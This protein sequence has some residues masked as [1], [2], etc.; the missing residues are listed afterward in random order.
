MTRLAQSRLRAGLCA[1]A[2]AGALVAGFFLTPAATAQPTTTP[3]AS[4]TASPSVT[5]S[6]SPSESPARAGGANGPSVGPVSATDAP[7]TAALPAAV[8]AELRKR[9]AEATAE[10]TTAQTA[11]DAANAQALD[12]AHAAMTA[13]QNA[14]RARDRLTQWAGYL[15]RVSGNAGLISQIFNDP[16]DDPL[17]FIRGA[18]D[19]EVFSQQFIDDL[20]TARDTAVNARLKADDASA[21]R[22]QASAKA[23][24]AETARQALVALLMRAQEAT[25][26]IQGAA[27]TTGA[28]QVTSVAANLGQTAPQTIIDGR[29]CPKTSPANTLRGGADAIG[30]EALC[31]KAVAEAA[32]PQAAL[33]IQAAFQMLGAP[34]ACGGVGRQDPFQFDCSSLVSRAYFLGAGID[35]AGTNWAPSTR[36]MVP[37]DGVPLA[38]WASYVDPKYVRPGDLVLYD[39]GGAAYRHVVMYIGSGFQLETNSC[40]DVAHVGTFSGF[41]PSGETFLV[42]RRVIAPGGYRIPDPRPIPTAGPTPVAPKP[43]PGVGDPKVGIPA[44]APVPAPAPLPIPSTTSPVPSTSTPVPTTTAPAPSS[45]GPTTSAPAPAPSTS[46]TPDP[47][48]STSGGSTSPIA[49]ESGSVT[50]T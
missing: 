26:A 41:N 35:T 50:T 36:D 14:E 7:N 22:N 47:S 39:T 29:A 33:A 16:N 8:V 42:A 43:V 1:S 34:Y 13:E 4:V 31:K 24:S 30:T 48:T 21:A 5:A 11:L 2:V 27:A 20:N 32:T 45:S 19:A 17:N 25:A 40:G 3:D 15:Y 18:A 9:I 46:T 10:R 49:T 28:N 38:W 37:W 6:D 12:T 23:E 44:P